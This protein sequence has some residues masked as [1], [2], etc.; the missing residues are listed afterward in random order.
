M[1]DKIEAI[2]QG[3]KPELERLVFAIRSEE[4]R[5]KLLQD[6]V[7]VSITVLLI[8]FVKM[9]IPDKPHSKSDAYGFG[10]DA[11]RSEMIARA[12]QLLGMELK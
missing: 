12:E 7:R 8:D 6:W 4:S 1:K 11:C 9:L 10:Y 3:L 2:V 5:M